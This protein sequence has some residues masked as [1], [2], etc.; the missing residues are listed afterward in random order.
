MLH[1]KKSDGS[2]TTNPKE[3][4]TMA[5]DFY[6]EVFADGPCDIGCMDELFKD[7]PKLTDKQRNQLDF[8]ID[9]DELTKAVKQLSIGCVPGIDGLPADFYKQFWD[10]LKDDLLEVFKSSYRKKELPTSCRRAVLSLLPKKGDLGLLKNWRP[11][12]ILCTDYKI[13]AK[14]LSNRLKLYLEQIVNGYQTYCIPDRTIMDNI[15]L[16]I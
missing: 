15:F 10:L 6:T 1:L 4:R 11:V 14:C 12:S 16:V 8:Q 13:L 7:L 5:I 3:M 2:V 9:I